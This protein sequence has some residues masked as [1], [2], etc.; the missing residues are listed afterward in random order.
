MILHAHAASFPEIADFLKLNF[1]V[2]ET[3]LDKKVDILNSERL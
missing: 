1:F 3:F 2:M